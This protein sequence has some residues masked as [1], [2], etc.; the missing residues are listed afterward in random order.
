MDMKLCDRCNKN[1]PLHEFYIHKDKGREG[2]LVQ[3]CKKCIGISHKKW[4]SANPGY[5]TKRDHR[6]GRYRPMSENRNCASWLG[7]FVAEKALSKF[8]KNIV[9][10]PNGNRGFDFLCNH[11]KKIDV[12]SSCLYY[13][14]DGRVPFWL[15]SIRGNDKADFFL[16]IAFNDRTNLKPIHVWLIPGYVINTK[17]SFSISVKEGVDK[18]KKYEKP[19]GEV[20]KC[21]NQMRENERMS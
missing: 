13:P 7:I 4:Q 1:K 6:V 14:K 21:C 9:R 20:I 19:L 3:P 2:K 16:L 11:G 15:W 18:W 5:S 12:K 17:Q 8:F 10:M